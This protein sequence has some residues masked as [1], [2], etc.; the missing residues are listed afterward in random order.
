[1]RPCS[2]WFLVITLQAQRNKNTLNCGYWYNYYAEKF[3]SAALRG[4][5]R[6][7][8][9]RPDTRRMNLAFVRV[10]DSLNKP[11]IACKADPRRFIGVDQ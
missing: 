3:C 1:M 8:H 9:E 11:I 2:G 6:A 7:D 10:I 5:A 4:T